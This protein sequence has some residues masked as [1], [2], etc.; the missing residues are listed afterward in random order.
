MKSKI[1]LTASAV[2]LLG[3]G[4]CLDFLPQEVAA[5]LGLSSEATAVVLLQVLAAAFLGTGFMNW[6]S[7]GKPMGGIYSRPLA[8]QNLLL[9]GVA[10]ITLDKAAL[11]A[12]MARGIQLSAILFTAFAIA[13][14]WLMFFHDPV[15]EVQK[16][17]PQP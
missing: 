14:C 8:L 1:V 6:L 5:A 4:V 9:F 12:S 7:K 2:F 17:Q 11:H 10:A 16:T 13:Y 15:Q 3:A